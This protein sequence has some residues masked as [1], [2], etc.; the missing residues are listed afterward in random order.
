MYIIY[1]KKLCNY[2]NKAVTLLQSRGLNFTYF[3][4][5]NDED[6]LLSLFTIYNWRTVP[7]VI[8]VKNSDNNFIGGYDD[9][10]KRLQIEV[11]E[12]DD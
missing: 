7:L 12:E 10:V 1:G 3:S 8:K 4:M 9:L 6:K 11:S 2:C 5:D